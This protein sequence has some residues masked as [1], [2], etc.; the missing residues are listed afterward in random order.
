[1]TA[2]ACP[3]CGSGRLHRS[4][5]RHPVEHIFSVLGATM[6]RC[7]DCN[8]RY[9]LFGHSMIGVRDLRMVSRKIGL[10]FTMAA[11]AA[12]IM[13]AIL[14]YSRA[15]SVPTSDSGCFTPIRGWVQALL[16]RV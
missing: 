2:T 10:T 6:R 7:H 4:R 11:A 9:A 12:F 16:F 13:V 14:W 5:R 8:R 1:M 15:Q 3:N